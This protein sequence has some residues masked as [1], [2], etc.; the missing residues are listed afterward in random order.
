[1]AENISNTLDNKI[2]RYVIYTIASGFL[3]GYTGALATILL[4]TEEYALGSTLGFSALGCGL[5]AA[6]SLERIIF[7]YKGKTQQLEVLQEGA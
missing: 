3:S 5:V 7:H 2:N 4:A 1:M 6:G